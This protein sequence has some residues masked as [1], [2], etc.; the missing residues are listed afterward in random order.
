MLKNVHHVP[1]SSWD[2]QYRSSSHTFHTWYCILDFSSLRCHRMFLCGKQYSPMAHLGNN[3]NNIIIICTLC[4]CLVDS[5]PTGKVS[6]T[7]AHCGSP[8]KAITFPLNKVNKLN[9]RKLILAKARPLY[10]VLAVYGTV[11]DICQKICRY[12]TIISVAHNHSQSIHFHK[13]FACRLFSFRSN[14]KRNLNAIAYMSWIKPVKWSQSCS[15]YSA[16]ARSAALYEIENWN[17][18]YLLYI[19]K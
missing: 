5:Q 16:R 19:S 3:N 7:T 1:N 9:E 6:P 14:L 13:R 17:K 2:F 4:V 12:I 18:C 10:D 15:G 8:K 11:F